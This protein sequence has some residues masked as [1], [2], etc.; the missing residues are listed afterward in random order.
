M[1]LP[2]CTI[3]KC[4]FGWLLLIPP[5]LIALGY[6]EVLCSRLCPPKGYKI[7]GLQPQCK[8]DYKELE[9][10]GG[11]A[12]GVVTTIS[13]PD[14]STAWSCFPCLSTNPVPQNAPKQPSCVHTSEAQSLRGPGPMQATLPGLCSGDREEGALPT[15]MWLQTSQKVGFLKMCSW[16][17]WALPLPGCRPALVGVDVRLAGAGSGLELGLTSASMSPCSFTSLL[18]CWKK[19]SAL[20][21]RRLL[22][23]KESDRFSFWSCNAMTEQTLLRSMVQ[24]HAVGVVSAPCT[25]LFP[26]T[27]AVPRRLLDAP[28]WLGWCPEGVGQPT[29]LPTQTTERGS[30]LP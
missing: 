27:P 14:F 6:E 10:P 29:P 28:L 17:A 3:V 23:L 11:S 26:W 5:L 9:V 20:L 24:M 19:L 4:Y 16:K 12:E 1:L 30:K 7:P 25:V 22:V 2:N 15:I 18:V 8:L 21:L 13:Q